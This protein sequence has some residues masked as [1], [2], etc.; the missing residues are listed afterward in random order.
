LVTADISKMF[1]RFKIPERDRRLHRFWWQNQVYEFSSLIF[2]TAA[3]PFM[4]NF[5]VRHIANKYKDEFP[6]ILEAVKTSIYVDDLSMSFETAKEAKKYVQDF[7][8]VYKK[9]D[10]PF[11][12]WACNDSSVLDMIPPEWQSKGLTIK[13]EEK[14]MVQKTLGMIWNRGS[15]TLTFRVEPW[16]CNKITTLRRI[17][18]YTPTLFDPQGLLLPLTLI[19]KIIISVICVARSVVKIDWDTPLEPL[20]GRVDGLAEVLRKWNEYTRSLSELKHI[21][22]PQA[23]RSGAA[24]SIQ[25]HLFTDASE[26]AYGACIYIRS[27]LMSGLIEVHLLCAKNRAAHLA[28]ARTIAEMELMGIYCG[29]KMFNRVMD[30]LHRVDQVYLWTDSRVCLYWISKPARQWK[31]FVCSQSHRHLCLYKRSYLET[32]TG[33]DESSGLSNK[34]IV[35]GCIQTNRQHVDVGTY[36]F[37]WTRRQVPTMDSRSHR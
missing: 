36:F 13:P 7:I 11:R 2:G 14:D 27:V 30:T 24:T 6:H 9:H 28:K 15:D 18:S 32:C 25:L 17:V 1:P 20:A 37:A 23:V 29:A 10:L 34:R 8:T 12:K 5:G 26:M 21:S 33:Q 19:A 22:F 4:A 35:Y 16:Q 3:A 31:A